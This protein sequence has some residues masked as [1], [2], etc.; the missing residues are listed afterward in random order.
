M[1]GR[2]C[3][4]KLTASDAYS[5]KIEDI[6]VYK[7]CS[8]HYKH[9]NLPMKQIYAWLAQVVQYELGYSILIMLELVLLP[10]VML[11][12]DL[13]MIYFLIRIKLY[14]LE[15]EEYCES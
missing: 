12:F 15:W 6:N 8:V 2:L 14:Y 7:Y 9:K 5:E 3:W 4:C 10:S 11:V 13:I 1:R